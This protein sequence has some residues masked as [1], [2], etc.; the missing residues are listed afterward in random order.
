MLHGDLVSPLKSDPVAPPVRRGDETR[1][2]VF[3][4]IVHVGRTMILIVLLRPF[5]AV[6]IPTLLGRGKLRR[7]SLPP[8][9][10]LRIPRRRWWRTILRCHRTR[11]P[12]Q[13]QCEKRPHKARL[14]CPCHTFLSLRRPPGLR[15][16]P[17]AGGSFLLQCFK[18][19]TGRQVV[20]NCPSISGLHGARIPLRKL[21]L[22]PVRIRLRQL[23]CRVQLRHLLRRQLPAHRPQV[24]LELLLV[25]R[26]DD[27]R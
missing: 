20:R 2:P 9:R 8:T 6:V 5:D 1:M 14:S 24:R 18:P 16:H 27:Q 4:T 22:V 7:S 11:R 3:I 23:T 17:C 21:R 26:P 10:T 19:R 13:A 15:I 25:T 12:E